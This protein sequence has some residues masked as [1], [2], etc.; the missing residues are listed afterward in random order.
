MVSSLPLEIYYYRSNEEEVQL[1]EPYKLLKPLA[2]GF[3]PATG[4]LAVQTPDQDPHLR[5]SLDS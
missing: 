3:P 4:A 5:L 1:T 2:C